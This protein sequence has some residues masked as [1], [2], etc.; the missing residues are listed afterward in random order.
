[1]QALPASGSKKSIF[2]LLW[3]VLLLILLFFASYPYFRFYL[4]PDAVS[5][6]TVARR[7]ATG[8]YTNA[9]N[10]LWSPFAPWLI[11]LCMRCGMQALFAAQLINCFAAVLVLCTSFTLLRRLNTD[12]RIMN[13]FMLVLPVLLLYSIY[14]QLFDDLWQVGFLLL[15]LLLVMSK[16]F[17]QQ[18]WKWIACAVIV[19]LAYFAKAYS[20]YF[21][22]LHLPVSLY[23]LVRKENVPVRNGLKPLATIV[24]C[25]WLVI[26]PWIYLL[27]QK[28]GQWTMSTAG[29]LNISWFLEGHKTLKPGI[30]YLVPPP[31]ADSPGNMEDPMINEGHLY[32]IWDSFPKYFIRQILR[33]GNALLQGVTV[34]N[35]ISA[36]LFICLLATAVFIFCKKGQSLF[37][38][39]YKI[40]LWAC[41]IMPLGYA[42]IV[43][44]ARYLWLLGYISLA[45]WAVWLVELK[46][47]FPGQRTFYFCLWVVAVSY[48]VYPLYD[49]KNMAH[50]G[51]EEYAT[52]E[53]LRSLGLKGS[54]TSNYDPDKSTIMA[55]LT[56]MQYYVVENEPPTTRDLLAEMQ[57][58]KVRYYFY[59]YKPSQE[60]VSGLKDANGQ[61]FPEIS[62][63]TVPGLKIFLV[64]SEPSTEHYKQEQQ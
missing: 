6:L 12:R 38:T 39:R 29:S 51:R 31:H 36:L 35:E 23:L 11:A 60:A 58:Y 30:T 57:R 24:I 15:Y 47:V 32:N 64:N 26:S 33:T 62:Q 7:Y 28:Y 41:L 46:K 20:F 21:V 44:E 16:G 5:Y 19:A 14:K 53:K 42:R 45:F 49:I 43:F 2:P 17:L 59:Y 1:M 22:L 61:S 10:G 27:H 8:D 48:I 13:A 54:F 3:S 4:D 52:A 55:Y 34:M 9:I 25:F 18:W 37:D 56:G 50:S 40:L 63:N